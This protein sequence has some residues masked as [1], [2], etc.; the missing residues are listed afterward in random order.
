M[1]GIDLWIGSHE[2]KTYL[3]AC[4]IRKRLCLVHPRKSTAIKSEIEKL[5][6]VGFIYPI[7]LTEWV[8]NPVPI[9]KK[10]GT[11]HI[12]VDYRKLNKVFPK[13][14]FPTSFIDQIIDDYVGC[15]FFSYMDG[16]LG[17]NQIKIIHQDQ[18]KTAFVCSWGTFAYRKLPFGLKNVVTTFQQA[19][20]YAFHDIKHKVQP[21]LDYFPTKSRKKEDHM[22]HLRQIFLHFRYYNI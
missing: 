6:K 19:M 4:P 18:H 8:S 17:Y 13:D 21:Y 10:Q 7:L 16:F 20:S 12:C 3:E 15:E 11:I 22:E 5:L 14:H 1:P 2:I 9:T